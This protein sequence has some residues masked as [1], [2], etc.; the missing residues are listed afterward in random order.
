ML[1]PKPRITTAMRV[2]NLKPPSRITAASSPRRRAW[3][4]LMVAACNAALEHELFR[5]DTEDPVRT[6]E[7]AFTLDGHAIEICLQDCACGEVLVTAVLDPDLQYPFRTLHPLTAKAGAAVAGGWIERRTGR[8]LQNGGALFH[9]TRAA[10]DFLTA[11]RVE[12]VGYADHGQ[13]FL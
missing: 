1:N 9:V 2:L 4:N 3:R 13:F 5:L 7:V 11:L 10:K 6:T 12:P 8:W